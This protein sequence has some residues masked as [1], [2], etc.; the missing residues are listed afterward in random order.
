[1]PKATVSGKTGAGSQMTGITGTITA[2][3]IDLAR[4]VLYLE[5]GSN[6][7]DVDLGGATSVVVTLAGQNSTVT[8]T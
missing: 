5:Q 4:S 8:V 6:I 1:M 7:K 2:C 3:R